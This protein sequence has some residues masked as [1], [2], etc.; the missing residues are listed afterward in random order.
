M[1]RGVFAGYANYDA[2]KTGLPEDHPFFDWHAERDAE[3]HRKIRE[4]RLIR[5]TGVALVLVNSNY[6]YRCLQCGAVW[7]PNGEV[8]GGRKCLAHDR[9]SMILPKLDDDVPF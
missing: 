3:V 2:W 6:R 4:R 8:G 9:P 1:S 7:P 5:E